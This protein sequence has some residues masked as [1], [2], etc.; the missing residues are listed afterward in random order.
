MSTSISATKGPIQLHYDAGQVVVTP[1]DQDRFVMVSRQAVSA[2]QNALAGER[3]LKQFK[4]DFLGQLHNW[5]LEQHGLVDQCYV[6]FSHTWG[7]IK[8][9]VV[10]K[11][12]KFDFALS[13]SIA[14]L[15]AKLLDLDWPCDILQIASGAPEELQ[16]FFNPEQSIQ[17]FTD[18]NTG[19]ASSKS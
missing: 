14:D 5:C 8:V 11:S 18:G 19:G 12:A 16:V 9:F 7:Y 13:D 10:A 17:V 4:D 6:S 1:E 15:E 2:C 3:F